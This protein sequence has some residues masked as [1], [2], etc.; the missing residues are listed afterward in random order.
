MASQFQIE[1]NKLAEEAAER[2]RNEREKAEQFVRDSLQGDDTAGQ[3][4]A[5][6]MRS[7]IAGLQ[8]SLD[9]RRRLIAELASSEL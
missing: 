6:T 4:E 8:S 7:Q 2:C 5:E 1:L 3:L 9:Q